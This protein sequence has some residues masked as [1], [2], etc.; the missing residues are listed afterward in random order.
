MAAEKPGLAN[1][2]D[3][4][5]PSHPL[6]NVSPRLNALARLKF[7][8][9]SHSPDSLLS[10]FFFHAVEASFRAGSIFPK[11]STLS[12]TG[13]NRTAFL[14]PSQI[15]VCSVSLNFFKNRTIFN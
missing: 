10:H 8:G 15:L 2:S 12:I 13:L 14:L 5:L 3:W 11:T 6:A 7:L 9:S 4:N 1:P